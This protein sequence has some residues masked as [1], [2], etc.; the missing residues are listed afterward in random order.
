MGM[1]TI[2]FVPSDSLLFTRLKISNYSTSATADIRGDEMPRKGV[3]NNFR[4]FVFTASA[5]A[6]WF[7]VRALLSAS[8]CTR[9]AINLL[10]ASSGPCYASHTKAAK[11]SG[12]AMFQKIGLT[13]SMFTKRRPHRFYVASAI[14]HFAEKFG[15]HHLR[16]HDIT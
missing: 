13:T 7:S 1:I 12:W 2:R 10:Q 6:R 8:L 5:S 14:F 16:N 3:N 15:T 9:A 11:C 4:F